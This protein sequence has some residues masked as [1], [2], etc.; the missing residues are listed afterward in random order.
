MISRLWTWDLRCKARNFVP[1]WRVLFVGPRITLAQPLTSLLLY[2]P[3]IRQSD[4]DTAI[5]FSSPRNLTRP[6]P[7]YPL[8]PSL[9]RPPLLRGPGSALAIY[10]VAV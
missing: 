10:E 1:A 9:S 6:D 2:G 8:A 5:A 3:L 4:C 7:S